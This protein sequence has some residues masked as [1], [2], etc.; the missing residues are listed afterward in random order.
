MAHGSSRSRK[1]RNKRASYANSTRRPG[2]GPEGGGGT[3]L[4][5]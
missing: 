2:R 4:R 1:R 5:R 3:V